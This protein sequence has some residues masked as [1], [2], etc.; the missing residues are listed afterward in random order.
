MDSSHRACRREAIRAEMQAID[1]TPPVDLPSI[2]APSLYLPTF[3][4]S[5]S[6]SL[7][8]ST[9]STRTF[10]PEDTPAVFR[11]HAHT[12]MYTWHTRNRGKK[13]QQVRLTRKCNAPKCHS[14]L[15]ARTG[16]GRSSIVN[17]DRPR[18]HARAWYARNCLYGHV[19]KSI[20][21][22][23]ANLEQLV[24]LQIYIYTNI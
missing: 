21:E 18:T 10:R 17:D 24:L 23:V 1:P 16:A 20:R 14:R 22:T 8:D 2:F 11:I 6:S 19:R 3:V 13:Q 12:R 9:F 4:P 5:S 15:Y 7:I